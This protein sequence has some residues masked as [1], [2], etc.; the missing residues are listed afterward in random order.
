MNPALRIAPGPAPRREIIAVAALTIVPLLPFLS[1]AF[2]MDAPVFMAVTRQ[3]LAHPLD[4][5]GFDM[6]WDPTA[7]QAAIFNRNPPLLSYYLAPFVAIFGEREAVVH[8]ALLVFPPMASLSFYGI[9]RRVVGQGLAPTAL[10]VATPAFLVLSAA[11][12]LD[13]PVVACMLV[14]V[15]AFLRALEDEPTRMRWELVA[16]VAA[17][18]A[19]VMKYV[20]FSI[21]P[22]MAAA[23]VLLHPRK[24]SASAR[25]LG[26]PLLVWGLWGLWTFHLYDAV[27]FFI[28]TDLVQDKSFEPD[29]FWNQVAS[30]PI[31]FGAALL[32]PIL[33]AIRSPLLGGRDWLFALGGLLLGIVAV[34]WVLPDGEPSRRNPLEG[35]ERVLAALGCAGAVYLWGVALARIRKGPLDVFLIL[36]FGGVTFWTLFLNWHVNSADALLAAPP[37]LLL[38]FR[39]ESLC[40]PARVA[41]VWVAL[42]LPLS[43]LLTWADSA[44]AGVYRWAAERI[45]KEIGDRPGNGWFVGHW[46]YQYYMERLGFRAVVPPQYE[47]WYGASDLHKGDWISSAR[48]VSQLDVS[49]HLGNYMIR[50][51]WSWPQ[52]FWIPLR[53]ANPDAGASFYSHHGGYVPFAWKDVPLDTIGLG[54]VI[55]VKSRGPLLQ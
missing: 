9:A 12:M 51:T 43:V 46:G 3:I 23:I 31:Y 29:H 8:A 49:R 30:T 18:A 55:Q 26:I 40:P 21:A 45:A 47:R 41:A 24:L 34:L 52:D 33:A 28:S 44:Q 37:A 16:G 1:A 5:F 7:P 11:V 25:V 36:W 19:G 10:L 38:L 35:D 27:H 39:S 32:F 2:S 54:Q 22:L 15:Y 50:G 53:T 4:P 17:A 42:A 13:V 6:I 14:A 20:G 48:N